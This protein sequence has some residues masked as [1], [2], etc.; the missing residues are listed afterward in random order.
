MSEKK[1][2]S[3]IENK[4][5]VQIFEMIGFNIIIS[6]PKEFSQNIM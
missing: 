6:I 5:E 3:E 4:Y 2:E 1:K